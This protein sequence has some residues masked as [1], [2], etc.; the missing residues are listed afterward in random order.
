M[1]NE[2]EDCTGGFPQCEDDDSGCKQGQWCLDDCCPC[3]GGPCYHGCEDCESDGITVPTPPTGPGDTPPDSDPNVTRFGNNP[4]CCIGRC[5]TCY[6]GYSPTVM[7]NQ[8]DWDEGNLP[9]PHVDLEASIYLVG[10]QWT[11]SVGAIVD[12]PHCKGY[13]GS[14]VLHG[15]HTVNGTN[16]RLDALC[17]RNTQYS[18]DGGEFI[19]PLPGSRDCK[20]QIC[21]Q[22]DC[23]GDIIPLHE[24]WCGQG[25]ICN[26]IKPTDE[27]PSTHCP[28]EPD[29][30]CGQ[31]LEMSVCCCKGNNQDD[32]AGGG[33]VCQTHTYNCQ[34]ALDDI[35]ANASKDPNLVDKICSCACY[36]VEMNFLPQDSSKIRSAT[37][38]P[39]DLRCVPTS[40]NPSDTCY[41]VGNNPG[42]ELGQGCPMDIVDCKCMDD[43]D[44]GEGGVCNDGWYICAESFSAEEGG[45]P[46]V[47]SCDCCPGDPTAPPIPGG[48]AGGPFGVGAAGGCISGP[49]KFKVFIAPLRIGA[50]AAAIHGK[51][52]SEGCGN[53]GD[54]TYS[55]TCP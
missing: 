35:D 37:I 12:N 23:N 30:C 28:E 10:C 2:K 20:T 14:I 42:C 43:S 17:I 25:V 34:N 48:G 40:F 26:G 3:C 54:I 6:P 9:Y 11:D 32:G 41:N 8:Q 49:F 45:S 47:L 51:E 27:S 5:C 38:D 21:S 18:S 50:T 46:P 22:T 53:M 24:I 55:N 4:T 44:K 52:C 33:G 39:S 19:T 7:G 1:T 36:S 31:R 13:L 15:S 16:K 29:R